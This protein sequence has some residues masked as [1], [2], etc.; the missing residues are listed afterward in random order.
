MY[1]NFEKSPE[2]VK[3][4]RIEIKNALNAE[5]LIFINAK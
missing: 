1:V 2:V 5:T 4:N 3:I